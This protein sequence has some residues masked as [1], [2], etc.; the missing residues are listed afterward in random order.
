MCV[1]FNCKVANKPILILSYL[2]LSYLIIDYAQYFLPVVLPLT[3]ELDEH[4]IGAFV[5]YDVAN[6][7]QRLVEFFL[8]CFLF[9]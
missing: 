6:C 2:I 9:S 7:T 5:M 1:E 8:S 4:Y 3:C